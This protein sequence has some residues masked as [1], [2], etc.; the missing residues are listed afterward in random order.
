MRLERNL[1]VIAMDKIALGDVSASLSFLGGAI[2]FM[3]VHR[4]LILQGRVS[5]Q[6][7]D[8][9]TYAQTVKAVE[10]LAS[11][12]VTLH[13]RATS[14]ACTR[15]LEVLQRTFRARGAYG[16]EALGGLID[17]L[18]QIIGVFR[19]EVA[20][21]VLVAVPLAHASLIGQADPIFGHAVDTAFPNASADLA[22]AGAC[23]ALGRATACV[24]HLMRV[25]ELAVQRVSAELGIANI[26]R[27]WGKLLSD[28]AKA[29]EALPKGSHRDAW[30]ES[31]SLLYHVK[32]A[33]RNDVMHPKRTYTI[34]EAERIFMAVRSYLEQLAAHVDTAEAQQGDAVSE[35]A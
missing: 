34:D 7:I 33:W 18:I 23:L 3:Q 29:I 5:H 22:E 21:Q 15:A 35:S 26:S 12:A 32:Q 13:L 6:E 8:T 20:G 14:T 2:K 28:M 24:F 10:T 19:D 1:D 27:E 31:H 17:P 30:S 16:S 11:T 9:E 25:M 4:T